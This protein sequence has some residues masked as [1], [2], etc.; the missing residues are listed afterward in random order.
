MYFF[1]CLPLPRLLRALR[2]FPSFFHPSTNRCLPFTFSRF[3]ASSVEGN[4]TR[5]PQNMPFWQDNYFEL[6]AIR[7]EQTQQ[8]SSVSASRQEIASSSQRQTLTGS[9]RH[10]GA[11]RPI[12]PTGPAGLC[13]TCSCYPGNPKPASASW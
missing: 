5:S 10:Q 11:C 1:V 4:Q 12:F 2:R 7:K 13:T 6:K 9:E 3:S 8:S